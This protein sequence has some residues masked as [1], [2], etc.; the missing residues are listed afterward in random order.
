[1][2]MQRNSTQCTAQIIEYLVD[3]ARVDVNQ[4]DDSNHTALS[5]CALF[6]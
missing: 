4:R 5:W 1:M 3:Y 2:Y 6:A